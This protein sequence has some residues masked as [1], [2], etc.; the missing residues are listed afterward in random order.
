MKNY[1]HSHL[2]EFLHKIEKLLQSNKPTETQTS[3]Y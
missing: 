3:D 2:D 1:L